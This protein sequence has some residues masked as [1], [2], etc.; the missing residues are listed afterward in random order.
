MWLLKHSQRVH[1]TK[2]VLMDC[3]G[4][5]GHF[6]RLF[7]W[8]LSHVHKEGTCGSFRQAY[9]GGDAKISFLL[10]IELDNALRG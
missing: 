8:G 3:Q 5:G 6:D 4:E 9:C 1:F 2:A 7:L 10:A